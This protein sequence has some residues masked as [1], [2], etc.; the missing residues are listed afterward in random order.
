MSAPEK[1][2]EAPQSEPDVVAQAIEKASPIIKNI[3]FGAVAGY[4]SGYAMK[5]VGKAMAVVL[6]LGFIVVQTVASEGYVV[7]DWEKFK[8]DFVKKIDTN[9]DDKI[10]V[11]DV[12]NWWKKVFKLLTNKLPSAGGFTLGFLYGVS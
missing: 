1:V 8:L 9:A 4:C 2:P 12:K 11:E 10:D 7:V 5:A 6:G 3:T